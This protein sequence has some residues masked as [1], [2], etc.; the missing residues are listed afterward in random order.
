MVLP[1]DKNLGPV[2]L[3]KE[4]VINET[5][6]MLMTDSYVMVDESE[7]LL[8]RD[9]IIKQRDEVCDIYKHLL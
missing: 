5:L 2:I 9:Y 3:D 6:G 7:W 4:W 1:A 8:K